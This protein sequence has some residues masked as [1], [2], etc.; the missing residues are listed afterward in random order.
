MFPR[1]KIAENLPFNKIQAKKKKIILKVSFYPLI[2]ENSALEV[3]PSFQ[4]FS[5]GK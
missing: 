2:K 1:G 3:K 4:I 5:L